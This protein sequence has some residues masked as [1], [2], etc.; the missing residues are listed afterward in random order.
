L[1]EALNVSLITADAR[2][3]RSGAARCEIEVFDTHA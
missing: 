3:K 1:A 2:I